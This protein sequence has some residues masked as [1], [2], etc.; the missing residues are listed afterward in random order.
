MWFRLVYDGLLPPKGDADEKETIRAVLRPQLEE[1]WTHLPL[2][3]EAATYLTPDGEVSVLQRLGQ[4]VYAPLVCE[5]LE[6]LAELDILILRPE[7]PGRIVTSSADIDNQL[8]TLLDAL[9]I[10]SQAQA[11]SLTAEPSTEAE[12]TYT[13]LRDDKLVSRLNVE[14]DRL[15][16]SLDE[17]NSVRVTIR[18]SLRPRRIIY[19]NQLLIA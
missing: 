8:K 4:H 15:L 19:A 7:R 10:P 17:S 1:L 18:V 16:G 12:P 11:I 5:R 9:S 3:G 13:L 6:L 2:V 14:T